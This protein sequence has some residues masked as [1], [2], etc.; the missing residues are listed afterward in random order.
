MNN[1]TLAKISEAE[2]ALASITEISDARKMLAIAEGLVTA[3][4]KEYK[5]AG[6]ISDVKEDRERAYQTAVKAGELRL[7]A[8]A[9]L[10]ELIKQEQEAGRLALKGRPQK[11]SN[12]G[13]FLE[14][15][16]LSLKDS[17]RAQR[18]A[19]HRDLIPVVVGRTIERGEDSIQT[20]LERE[21]QIFRCCLE[22]YRLQSQT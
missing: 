21:G 7:L 5:A 3:A 2:R 18:V 9:R 22:I 11:Y 16:G 8:E 17:H 19:E 13:I 20:N 15:L 10:G 1:I 12:D 4:C 6:M 14:D